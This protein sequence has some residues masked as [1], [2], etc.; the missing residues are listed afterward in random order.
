VA[1][2]QCWRVTLSRMMPPPQPPAIHWELPRPDFLSRVIWAISQVED[3]NQDPAALGPHGEVGLYQFK[4]GTW[5][6]ITGLPF[7]FATDPHW[8]AIE[9]RFLANKIRWQLA[10]HRLDVTPYNI[11]LVWKT[12]NLDAVVLQKW[13]S[14]EVRDYAQ[15]VANL[16]TMR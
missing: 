6:S 15:R 7:R 14:P 8:A 9:A 3:P 11:A 1:A 16:F 5:E 10:F 12:G 4:Q 13:Q 2:P